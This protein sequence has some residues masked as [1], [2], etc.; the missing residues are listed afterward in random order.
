MKI[1]AGIT[2]YNPN[3]DRL[4]ENIEAIFLQVEEVV[5]VD[6]GSDNYEHIKQLLLLDYPEVVVIQ[7][8]KNLG[9][10]KALNQMFEYAKENG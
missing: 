1:L 9:V 10:A 8:K 4:K 6:N 5:C 3:I 7:N 2:I